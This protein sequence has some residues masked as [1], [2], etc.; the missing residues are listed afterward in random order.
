MKN[1]ILRNIQGKKVLFLFILTN[2]VYTIMLTLTIPKVM[3]FSG[4]MKL[5]DMM[6]TGYNAEYVNA[7][8]NA[9]GENGR[10]AYLFTQIPADL[11]F[12]GLFGISYCLLFAYL[13][14]K[15]GKLNG[16]FWGLCWLPVL[17][18]LFDYF[19]NFGIIALLNSYPDNSPFLAQVTNVFS[20]LKSVFTT[21]AFTALII[22]LIVFIIHKLAPKRKDS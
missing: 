14:N 17:A 11:I 6:P 4:G 20:I 18:G 7:L 19:E 21:L 9:L 22:L 15:I 10:N 2:I 8:L 1:W 3:S 5:L 13:L 12:P 16:Y